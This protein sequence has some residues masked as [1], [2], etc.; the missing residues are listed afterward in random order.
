MATRARIGIQND[1]GTI[2]SVYHHWDGYPEWLGKALRQH[3]NT[4]DKVNTLIDGGD[5]SSC[6]TNLGFNNESRDT[7]GPLYYSERGETT[8]ARVTDSFDDY[9]RY[10]NA[11]EEFYYLFVNNEWK[12]YFL[13]G[14][15]PGEPLYSEKVIP[16]GDI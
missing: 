2:R 13:R 9:I 11:L 14:E 7:T 1:D 3:F 4:V 10:N 5:M 12:C 8:P 16:E 6:Y 15:I